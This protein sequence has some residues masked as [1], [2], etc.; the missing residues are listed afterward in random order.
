LVERVTH[1]QL[2]DPKPPN[3][4]LVGWHD[5]EHCQIVILIAHV[6]EQ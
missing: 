4:F 2:I 1:R 5:E 3:P 6:R